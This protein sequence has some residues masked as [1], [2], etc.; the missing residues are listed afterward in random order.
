MEL[1]DILL[2]RLLHNM[3]YLYYDLINMQYK[4][5]KEYYETNQKA[6]DYLKE[7]VTKNKLIVI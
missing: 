2:L 7:L 5:C 3:F 1:Q 4:D 6:V